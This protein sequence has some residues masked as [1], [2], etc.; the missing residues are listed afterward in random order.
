[1]GVKE[2][3]GEWEGISSTVQ[4]SLAKTQSL[5]AGILERHQLSVSL[6]PPPTQNLA[7]LLLDRDPSGK[8]TLWVTGLGAFCCSSWAWRAMS[9]SEHVYFGCGKAGFT[10]E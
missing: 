5:R 3:Q 6:S 9:T 4:I 10:T 7:L 8:P 2:I 1:M